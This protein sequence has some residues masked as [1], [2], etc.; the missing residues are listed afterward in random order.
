[1]R[2]AYDEGLKHLINIYEVNKTPI[3]HYQKS[4]ERVCKYINREIV[5]HILKNEDN[6]LK[7]EFFSVLNKKGSSVFKEVQ[8]KLETAFNRLTID[9]SLRL[10]LEKY[11]LQS[12][13]DFEFQARIFKEFIDLEEN[14]KIA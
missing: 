10:D 1:M 2:E 5:S 13:K 9:D 14:N 6:N 8:N 11:K 4:Y 3:T 7:F 12:K